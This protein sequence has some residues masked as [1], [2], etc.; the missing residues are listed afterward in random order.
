M[1]QRA[2]SAFAISEHRHWW[3]DGRTLALLSAAGF[4]LKAIFVK[5][6]YAAGPVDAVS[7]LA[8]RMGLAL[9]AFLWLAYSAQGDTLGKR[10]WLGLAG[11]GLVGYYLSSLFDF[12]GLQTI[13]A[14]LERLILFTYPSLV[15]LMEAA[16]H[17]RP[18]SGRIWAAMGLCYLGLL[19]AFWHDLVH[20]TASTAVLIGGGWVFLSA[21][22]FSLYYLGTGRYVKRIGSTRLAG[23]SGAMACGFV[24]GHFLLARPLDALAGLP[25]G[26]WG[27]ALAMALVSTVLPIWLAARA[28]ERLGASRAAA[29]GTV[30]PVLTIAFGWLI[31]GEPFSLLQV[32]GLCLVLAGITWISKAK[33]A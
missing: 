8:L 13:S 24:L 12:L 1:I 15:L 19:A 30:G 29:M 7:L 3:Q 21:I 32:V 20:T 17:R 23:Y 27:W 25:Q 9:P 28:V 4:S 11:L 14:G 26:V 16:W 5:L 6:A 18:I 10:D 31:L 22:T 33:A 2:L